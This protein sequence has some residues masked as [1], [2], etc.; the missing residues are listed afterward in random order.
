V[1]T[2]EYDEQRTGKGMLKWTKCFDCGQDFH[3]AV[4]L[5]LGW[6]AWKTYLGRPDTDWNR[7]A[8]MGV[9]GNA[10]WQGG[11]R[12]ED[13]IPVLEVTLALRR[14]F[15][16]NDEQNILGVQTNLAG[17]L[18]DLGR[19]HEAV[20]L[21]RETF[22]R[23][24][25][26]LGVSN[27]CTILSGNNVATSLLGLERWEEAKTLLGEKLLPAAR[28]SLGA[29][30]N[31]TLRLGQNLADA[32]YSNPERTRD[33]LRLN[34]HRSLRRRDPLLNTGDD[35]LEAETIM[36]HVVER[37]RRVFGPA[38]PDTRRAE[39]MLFLVQSSSTLSKCTECGTEDGKLVM[40]HLASVFA[41]A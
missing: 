39:K 29:D 22:D 13:A 2:K 1:A 10:L 11:E 27:E 20:V 37:R 23:Q 26:T 31:L 7:C 16:P 25:A 3:G 17:C 5:A 14:R 15:W 19:H 24:V 30:H 9:L 33:D 34:Q 12:P 6:A 40:A 41:G 32:L 38:H 8:S 28:K 18:D 21:K 36:K 4:R 35:L